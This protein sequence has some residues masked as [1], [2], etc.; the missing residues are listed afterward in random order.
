MSTGAKGNKA[1]GYI[2]TEKRYYMQTVRRQPVVLAKGLGA[3]V[4]D[5]DGK[6][7]LDF[8]AGWAVNN[9]GHCHPAVVQ[10]IQEQAATLTQTSNQFYT[11]PQ[12]KL[13]ELLVEHSA[14][15]RVFL[16]NSGAEAN[17]G[18]VKIGRKYGRL[19]RN[20]A[21]EVITA[22]NSFHGR[23][24]NMVAAT[25]QP[26]YQDPW[27]PLPPGFVH[28]EF[29][30]FDAIVAATN[31]RTCAI[32]LEPVQGEAGVII[33]SKEYMKKVR[34][35]CTKN[36]LVLIYDE[37]QTGLGRLGTLFGYESFGVEPDVI[38]LAKA[39]GNGIPVGAFLA[40]EK[41]AVLDFGDHGSTFG[42]NPLSTA[43]AYAATKYIIDHDV[44]GHALKIGARLKAGLEGLKEYFPFIKQ[45]RGMGMLIAVEFT[46][47]LTPKLIGL[48]NDEGILVNPVRPNAIRIM[49]PLTLTA[50]EVD[51]GVAR[52]KRAMER[53]SKVK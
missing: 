52:L 42:G 10:A 37:V 22:L 30:N 31:D 1:A 12:L 25:G 8:T 9:L 43:A 46:E 29:G 4:W 15:D 11:L 32:M 24:L 13:V 26:H 47:E 45:V 38:S 36:N 49:P 41:F 27:K 7:Y 51:E 3:R 40:K 34:D 6:E 48:T 21:F 14:F 39:L 18:A 44:P 5:V 33:P 17:E 20:G 2:E 28:V 53:L 16:C 23:T 50:Q 35:W 19:H